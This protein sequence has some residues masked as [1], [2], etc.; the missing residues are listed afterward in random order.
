M[1]VG[2]IE[3]LSLLSLVADLYSL[4]EDF[5]GFLTSDS[6]F[7]IGIVIVGLGLPK[8]KNHLVCQ[9]GSSSVKSLI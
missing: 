6:N 9:P 2:N 7:K 4:I 1:E 8:K 5:A 3:I